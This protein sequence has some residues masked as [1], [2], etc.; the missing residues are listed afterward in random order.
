MNDVP[1]VHFEDRKGSFLH[2]LSVVWVIPFLALAMALVVAWQTYAARGPVIMIEFADGAGITPRETELRFRD[3]RVGVVE[4]LS[5][6]EGLQSVIA[7]VRVIQ[8]VAPYIDSGATFWT[9]T[10]E[11]SAS[12]VT[13]LDT[14]FTGV[15]IEGSWDDQIGSPRDSFQGLPTAPLYQPGEGG[16]QLALRSIPG[17]TLSADTPILYR[18]IEIGRVG[19]ARISPEGNFAIAEAIIYEPHGR[20]VTPST[21]F[22]DTSGFSF[23]IGAGGAQ[24]NF[25]SVASLVAGGITFDTFVSGGDPV[26]DGS[27]FEVFASEADARS[28]IFNAAEVELL[29]L[30]VVF[31]DNVSGLALGAPV[32]LSGLRVGSVESVSGLVDPETFGDSRVRLN[33]VLGIQPVRLGL[34]DD[35]SPEEALAFI[36]ERVAEG[37]RARLA[38]GNIFTGGLKIELVDVPDAPPARVDVSDG[39][40]PVLP[41]TASSVT[42]RAASV[43]GVFSRINSLPIE[44]LLQSA[45][46]F[47]ESASKLIASDAVRDAPEDFAGLLSDLRGVVTSDTVQEIPVS[48]NAAILRLDGILAQIEE[49]Q[50]VAR[51]LAAID[52][53]AEA[54]ERFGQSV[55]GVPDMVEELIA[56]ATTAAG[57]PLSELTDQVS[58]ILSSA[59][60]VI[61]APAMQDLPASLAGALD[62]LNRTLAELREGGAVTNVN[63][64]LASTREAADAVAL[65]TR[66]LPQLVERITQVFDEASATISGYDRGEVL[67]RDAQAALRDISEASDA[68]TALARLLERNPSAL[69]RGR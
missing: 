58:E 67:S 59:D 35:P 51:I 65:S 12:G 19:P 1:P 34:L 10:P 52:A 2:S 41:A 9:V 37:L 50:A 21:R 61:S 25:S 44:D 66:A 11:F 69:I 62:E 20:L 36:E 68:I 22:W 5:F 53:A 40:L 26:G 27:V 48:L 64:T 31:D 4:D 29:E 24:L 32:E 3:V 57:L 33:V 30:R 13:G 56:V 49:D 8:E 38:S 15:F 47:M 39:V 43:E 7:K 63:A 46:D 55:T 23:N 28:S 42:D 16:L 54:S 17:G 60:D 45:I 14:V 6:G 18:G